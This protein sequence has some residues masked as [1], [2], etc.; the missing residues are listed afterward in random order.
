[1]PAVNSQVR[2]IIRN[3]KRISKAHHILAMISDLSVKL[4]RL[5]FSA[6][7]LLKYSILHASKKLDRK[8][9]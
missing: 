6:G 2:K 8:E 5:D 3:R 7:R 1:M 4:E 9:M